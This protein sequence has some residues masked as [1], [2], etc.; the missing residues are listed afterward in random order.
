MILAIL[1]FASTLLTKQHVIVDVA[2]GILLAELC[3]CIGRKTNLYKVYERI[4]GRIEKAIL[5]KT[6]G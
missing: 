4:G 2:G 5:R 3:F 6:E 1:V